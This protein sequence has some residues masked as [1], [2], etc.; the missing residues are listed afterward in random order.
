MLLILLLEE[1]GLPQALW[2][3][4]LLLATLSFA[5]LG[6]LLDAALSL[7]HRLSGGVRVR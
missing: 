7:R 3:R 1:E 2:S 4:Y 6:L 5:S